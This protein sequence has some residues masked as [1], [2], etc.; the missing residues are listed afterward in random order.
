MLAS[1]DP[2]LGPHWLSAAILCFEVPE[3]LAFSG[4]IKAAMAEKAED[5][6]GRG[7]TVTHARSAT[8]Q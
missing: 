4:K 2:G 7:K 5:E 3:L 6:E 1:D 8:V